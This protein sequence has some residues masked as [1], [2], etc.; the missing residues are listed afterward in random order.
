MIICAWR[1]YGPGGEDWASGPEAPFSRVAF[2]EE[3]DAPKYAAEDL[4]GLIDPDP[5]KAATN[6]YDMREVIARIV[7]R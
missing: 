2:D 4:Y 7:D 6:V 3:A 1:G 5:A